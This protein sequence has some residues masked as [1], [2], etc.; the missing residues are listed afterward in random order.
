[1]RLYPA[2]VEAA[3]NHGLKERILTLNADYCMECGC[4]AYTCPAGRPLTQVMRLAKAEL[5]RQKIK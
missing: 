5:R 3:L 4:C 2:A 1:M